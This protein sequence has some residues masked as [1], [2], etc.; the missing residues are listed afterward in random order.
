[1]NQ[2]PDR[3]YKII[4]DCLRINETNAS[5]GECESAAR[6][7][8]ELLLKYNLK[9]SD[10]TDRQGKR[11]KKSFSKNFFSLA[12]KQKAHDSDW[13]ARLVNVICRHNMSQAILVPVMGRVMIVGEE[14]NIEVILYLVD[15]LIPRIEESCKKAWSEY[16]YYMQDT[17]EKRN[18]FRRGFLLGCVGGIDV[19]LTEQEN[20]LYQANN[21]M[22]GMIKVNTDDLNKFIEETFGSQV[23]ENDSKN[24]QLRKSSVSQVIGY[25]AGKNMEINKGIQDKKDSTSGYIG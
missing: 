11:G 16:N 25:Q 3:I 1:M 20:E 18:T 21:S 13:V 2:I 14:H 22:L 19:K 4:G 5:I 15:F 7:V 6:R 23:K 12:G 9:L 8:Q 24:G 17:G 10:V